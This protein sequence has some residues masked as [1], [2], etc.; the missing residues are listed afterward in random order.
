MTPASVKSASR[1]RLFA[2]DLD[3]TLLGNPEATAR[4]A[5]EWEALEPAKRPLLVYNS[6]RL[7]EEV[8]RVISE[9]GLPEPDYIIG[10]VGTEMVDHRAKRVL[11]DYQR[12]QF[13][14]WDARTVDLY[15]A[16]VHEAMRQ[17]E[18][19]QTAFKS[20]WYLH[21]AE[22]RVIKRIA[23]ELKAMGLQ[24]S[25]VYSSNRDLDI[26]PKQASKG[27]ALKW[28]LAHLKVPASRVVVSGDSAGDASMYLLRG[29]R[30]ILVE[31][32]QPELVERCVK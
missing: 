10:G 30:G 25:V 9:Q 6:G 11:A 27:N 1:I 31:N 29:V 26:L 28:L 2:S 22:R 5:A 15:M 13:G 21:G 23:A 17:P 8:V 18:R 16:G 32:A 14:D 19:F 24:V 3:G 20:S 12:D 7:V 4:F